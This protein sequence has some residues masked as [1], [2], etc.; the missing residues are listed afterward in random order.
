MSNRALLIASLFLAVI[1]P[2]FAEDTGSKAVQ[3]EPASGNVSFEAIGRPSM[4]KIKGKG[5]ALKGSLKVSGAKVTGS[6]TFELNSLETGLSMRDKHMKEK[7]LETEKYPQA[8]LTLTEL[9]LPESA[10]KAIFTSEKI[11]FKGVMSLH[12]VNKPVE[13][14][15]DLSRSGSGY[16]VIA[17]FPIKTPDFA[18][19]TPSFAGITLADNVTV[20]VEFAAPVK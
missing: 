16:T 7:Y 1:H 8:K 17:T 15:A 11:P 2:S 5:T 20:T 3:L 18:I 4:L 19:A 6:S 12:G 14:I 9:T 13:G 10:Q